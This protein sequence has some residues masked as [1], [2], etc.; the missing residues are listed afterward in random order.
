MPYHPHPSEECECSECLLRHIMRVETKIL[1]HLRHGS[2]SQ[3]E[4]NIMPKTIAVGATANAVL[5]ATGSDGNPYILSAADTISLAAAVP[6]DVS[7]QS[8]PPTFNADGTA[9]VVVT[10]VNADPGDAITAT[11]DGVVSSSD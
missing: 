1:K 4:I 6:A 7:F 10:G 3:L 5:A 9:T 2:I 11:V 8:G